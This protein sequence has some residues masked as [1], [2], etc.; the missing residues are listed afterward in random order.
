MPAAA[1]AEAAGRLEAIE[2]E[3]RRDSGNLIRRVQDEAVVTGILEGEGELPPELAVGSVSRIG[4]VARALRCV[5]AAATLEK[6]KAPR[7][8]GA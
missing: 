4:L 7:R 8:G 1:R 3:I 2:D 5:P 6:R